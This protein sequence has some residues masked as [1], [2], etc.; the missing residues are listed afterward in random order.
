MPDLHVLYRFSVSGQ[1]GSAAHHASAA[2]QAQ[3]MGLLTPA[4][5]L[6]RPQL[7]TRSSPLPFGRDI[8]RVCSMSSE[9]K[10]CLF[11]QRYLYQFSMSMVHEM[12]S[13]RSP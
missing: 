3:L 8:L 2:I 10:L 6:I 11:G 12:A 9:L 13:L 1:C 4:A 7:L 5:F